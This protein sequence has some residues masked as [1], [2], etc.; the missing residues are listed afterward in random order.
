QSVN[1][2][3]VTVNGTLQAK[4]E[5]TA[6]ANDDLQNLIASTGI[7][8]IFVDSE[9]RITRYTAPAVGLFNLIETDIGRSLFDL[10]HRLIY[11]ELTA[12]A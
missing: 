5:E 1:E 6:K 12:D 10:T 3:L 7:A 4:V 8:T 11:P 9:M 2:E